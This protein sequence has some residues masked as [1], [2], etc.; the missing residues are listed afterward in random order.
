MK[1][2]VRTLIIFAAMALFIAIPAKVWSQQQND[3]YTVK[4]VVKD[5][6]TQRTLEY[7]SISVAG[8]N[9]GT[10]TNTNGEF[11]IKIKE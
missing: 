5:K 8:T 2:K 7:A 4:G 11:S 9:I 6:N 3:Y 1:T 10:I